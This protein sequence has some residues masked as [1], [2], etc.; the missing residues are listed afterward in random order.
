VSR[1][2]ELL[3]VLIG[4]QAGGF[5]AQA[6]GLD[7]EPG[8]G[9]PGISGAPRGRSWDAIVSAHAPDL[10]GEA[11][12][13]VTLDDGTIVVDDDV[14]DGSLAPLADAIE[15]ILTR[16]YRAAAVRNEDDVWSAVAETVVIV[17]LPEVD[18]D[19]VDLSVVGGV[20]E[21]TVDGD[22]TIRP[23]RA[24][25]ALTEGYGDVALHAERVDDHMFA[26]DLF[27]L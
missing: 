1:A 16:P 26:V 23:L 4:A 27:P 9:I 15:A 13:F 11:V 8:L 18:G 14:P 24:L 25:D 12:T 6:P 3:A 2:R 17:E 10:T 22:P 7:G 5:P 21:L 19:L 20:R